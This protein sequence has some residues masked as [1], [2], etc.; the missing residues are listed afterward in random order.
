MCLRR[1]RKLSVDA[2][3]RGL[4]LGETAAAARAVVTGL[5]RAIPLL[6][7]VVGVLLVLDEQ[8]TVGA[9]V[10]F[11]M[12]VSRVS[13]PLIQASSLLQEHQKAVYSLRL[14]GDLMRTPVESRNGQLVP[15]LSGT[16]EFDDVAF[17]YPNTG[18]PALKDVTLRFEAGQTIGIVGRSGS[19]KTTITRILQ[20]LHQPQSGIVRL[21]GHDIKEIET[22]YLRSHIGVVL[23]DNF[24]FR[25]TVRE[26]I[27]LGRPNASVEEIVQAADLAGAHEF[28]QRLQYGYATLLDEN[29]QN[30]S[31][32]Q[33]QRLAIARVLLTRPRL[34]I[35]DE[36]TSALDP[37]SEAVV[38]SALKSICRGRTSIIVTH[39]LSFV[40]DADQIVVLD[41]GAV[42]AVGTHEQL[43]R[44]S[45][46]YKQFWNQQAKVF[47]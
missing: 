21:D 46:I 28:I 30:L 26:N 18:S 13:G 9:L 8:M 27:A 20:K 10:A 14:L 34:L 29:A 35:F 44:N 24:F 43:L 45:L 25:G 12:L 38:R 36:A 3:D 31:G 41:R 11:N 7:G 6:V 32:G 4:R 17:T 39:R 5:E 40:R 33:R 42:A 37:E 1:W 15:P 23:Q 19:G 16:I 22:N 47:A 2:A